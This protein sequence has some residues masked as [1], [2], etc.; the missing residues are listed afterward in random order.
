MKI[1]ITGGAGFIASHVTDKYI[2][3]GHDVV[4]VDNLTTGKEININPKAKFYKIDIQDDLDVIFKTEKPDIVNHHAAQMNVRVSVDNPIKDAKT[5]IMGLINLL[6]TS[7]KY[8]VKKF[9]FVS[10][11][12]VVYSEDNIFPIKETGKKEPKSPYGITKYTGEQYVKFFAKTYGLKY[13]I[14]RYSNVYG[15][16]QNPKGEAG[17]ISIFSTLMLKNEQPII[18]GDGLQL[19]DYVYVQDVV[20][21]NVKVLTMGDNEP[22]NVGTSVETDV[23]QIFDF[24]KEI[25]E[26][27]GN[28]KQGSRR[29]FH[30]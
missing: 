30:R 25:T 23:N 1:L 7:V 8:N 14:L 24:I 6:K 22:Y 19:R 4:I 26:Y 17:V 12:G 2:E 10:S 21:L 3:E 5:N 15:P 9:I 16:R 20:E 28:A 29:R 27:Q 11:G 13:S 18:F